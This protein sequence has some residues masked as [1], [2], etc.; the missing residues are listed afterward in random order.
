MAILAHLLALSTVLK[1]DCLKGA[2]FRSKRGTRRWREP[3]SCGMAKLV[4]SVILRYWYYVVLSVILRYWYY[5]V[6]S[7]VLRKW[8]Y[9]FLTPLYNLY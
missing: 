5:V 7:A 8:C 4:L 3:G 6:L 2:F 9:T 1:P